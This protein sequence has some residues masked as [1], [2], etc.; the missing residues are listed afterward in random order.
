MS[1]WHEFFFGNSYFKGT[2][3]SSVKYIIYSQKYCI[4]N[5]SRLN[6]H[7]NKC[8]HI[9]DIKMLKSDMNMCSNKTKN[10]NN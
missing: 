5:Q 10:P 4:I 2:V 6:K 3:T 7:P 8:L 1:F 9:L